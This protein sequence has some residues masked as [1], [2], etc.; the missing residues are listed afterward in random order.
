[1]EEKAKVLWLNLFSLN[2]WWSTLTPWGWWEKFTECLPGT[3]SETL[4]VS[5][6]QSSN[7][8][9]GL[10]E[11]KGARE[12]VPPSHLHTNWAKES[13]VYTVRSLV[14]RAD[15]GAWAPVHCSS[16]H[17]S[18]FTIALLVLDMLDPIRCYRLNTTNLNVQC[19]YRFFF[20]PS[21]KITMELM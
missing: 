3:R 11:G 4:D 8:S 16:Y 9:C 17:I 15:A 14:C 12:R 5:T 13:E 1:M 2:L 10:S 19:D 6:T 7:R 21:T 18:D 20:P